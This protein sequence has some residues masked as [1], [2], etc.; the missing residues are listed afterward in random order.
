[1]KLNLLQLPQYTVLLILVFGLIGC[2][3]NNEIVDENKPDD[4][5]Y[6]ISNDET[7][8]SERLT[9][10]DFDI[11]I[12]PVSPVAEKVDGQSISLQLIANIKT[13]VVDGVQT[14]ATMA[15]VSK[16]SDRVT[17][18]YSV[19]GAVYKG[20]IDFLE[21]AGGSAPVR[22][23]RATPVR[24]RASIEF[25]NAKANAV[26]VGDSH[27]FIAHSS[28]DPLLTQD[29]GYSAV[30]IFEHSG[31]TISSNSDQAGLPGFAANSI[32]ALD[33]TV[34]VTSG[35]N[36][37]LS[38]FNFEDKNLSKK[39]GYIDIPEARWV[40]ANNERI[41][42]LASNP[43]SGIG[44]L[45]VLS[46]NEGTVLNKFTFEGAD[47]PEAKNTVEIKGDLA[48]IA[49]GRSG[50]H[51]I[52]LNTGELI[53]NIPIPDPSKL[54]LSPSVVE[55][56]AAS[57]D[58]E[59]IFIANGEAGVYVAVASKNLNEYVTGDPLT[60]E[61][62]GSLTFDELQSANHVS[63]RDQR[64]VVAAGLGGVKVVN[65]QKN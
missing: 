44:S 64:L 29:E 11:V 8:L 38:S 42:V 7:K 22:G 62:L 5:T 48:L 35:S 65:L 16:G 4:T 28:D 55:S 24:V 23:T 32:H 2:N 10:S 46:V 26:Y 52:D 61:L 14:M 30:Q 43:A 21:V 53:A 47:T 27:I 37:G 19:R 59:Y 17:V 57:A 18:S 39:N 40:D 20:G 25:T 58:E 31:F 36:A 15:S 51:L 63:Y 12:V 56:N 33:N 13:P 3:V 60:V 50:T 54:G 49:A 6:R 45:Y 41:V 1:M 34:Y 9:D